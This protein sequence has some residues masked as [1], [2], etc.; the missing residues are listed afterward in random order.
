MKFIIFFIKLFETLFY[1]HVI[2]G[3]TYSFLGVCNWSYDIGEWNGFS[4][5][6]MAIVMII[7]TIASFEVMSNT[8]KN[9]RNK[10]N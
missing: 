1:F 5:F 6:L 7:A 8:V 3:I 4:R 2:I 9:I 10:N